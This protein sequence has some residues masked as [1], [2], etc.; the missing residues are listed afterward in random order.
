[1]NI[2][3]EKLHISC[4][5]SFYKS[6]VQTVT[7]SKAMI[8]FCSEFY[9]QI[10]WC[11]FTR[12]SRFPLILSQ[13]FP[14]KQENPSFN[15]CRHTNSSLSVYLFL[16]SE[17]SNGGIKVQVKRDVESYFCRLKSKRASCECMFSL[18][19]V[20]FYHKKTVQLFIW[21]YMWSSMSFKILGK[22]K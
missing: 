1:M 3:K 11:S 17:L 15:A 22:Y 12:G 13:S 19:T 10:L 2:L 21:S 5:V 8:N 14:G 20:T 16:N 9:I 18:E 4:L 6:T 7:V